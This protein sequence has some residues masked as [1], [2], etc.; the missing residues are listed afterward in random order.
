MIASKSFFQNLTFSKVSR[1]SPLY[2][3]VPVSVLLLEKY[4]IMS[5]NCLIKSFGPKNRNFLIFG[6][7]K[8]S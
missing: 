5:L 2:T 6:K 3:E 1:I 8:L 7:K 4:E